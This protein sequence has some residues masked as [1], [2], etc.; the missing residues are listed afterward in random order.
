MKTALIL[1]A[2]LILISII[3]TLQTNTAIYHSFLFKGL[4]FLLIINILFCTGKR[5]PHLLS[6]AGVRKLSFDKIRHNFPECNEF[7]IPIPDLFKENLTAFS[8]NRG[9]RVIP[10]R[11]E[12]EEILYARKGIISL[13]ANQVIHWALI[14]IFTGAFIGAFGRS[15]EVASSIGRITDLPENIAKMQLKIRIDD[16]TTL[17]NPDQSV[18]NWVTRLTLLTGETELAQGA[19]S[20]NHPFQYHGVTFYQSGY[21]YQCNFELNQNG[22]TSEYQIPVNQIMNNGN[23]AFLLEK[24]AAGQYALKVYDDSREPRT[25]ELNQ[26][27]VISLPNQTSLK[28]LGESAYTILK[29]KTDPGN[30]VVMAGLAIL[31][32]GFILLYT[33]QYREIKVL[34]HHPT[35]TAQI[36]VHCKNNLLRE[37]LTN[38]LKLL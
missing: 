3:G 30:P 34:I 25:Y 12:N 15:G 2:L 14:I 1:M 35:Q 18:E 33:G 16:F 36:S 38:E 9:Y 19:A 7:H 11:G 26:G 24:K 37:Q 5:F 17:Y 32:I 20:V 31:A 13:I 29:I 4:L 27:T 23:K 28:L 10:L 22:M 21:G 6:K 8:R